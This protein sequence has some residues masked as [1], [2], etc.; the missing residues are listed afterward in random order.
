LHSALLTLENAIP[1]LYHFCALLSSDPYV[2]TRPQFGFEEDGGNIAA[3]VTLPLA[4]DPT[5]RVACSLK[6]WRTER[7]AAKD[8]AFEAYKMLHANGLVNDNLLPDKEDDDALAA[9]FQKSDKTASMIEVSPALDSWHHVAACQA[10]NP[11]VYHCTQ[12][13]ILGIQE[14]PFYIAFYLPVQLPALPDLTLFWN[15]SKRITVK[16]HRLQEATLSDE[17]LT[18][19][20]RLTRKILNSVHSARIDQ[21]RDDFPWLL[22]PSDVTQPCWDHAALVEWDIATSSVIPASHLISRGITDLNRWGQIKV[23]ED[24][25]KWLARSIRSHP[26]S[27]SEQNATLR[28]VRVAKRRDFLY[29]VPKGQRENEAYT[30]T[31]EFAASDCSVEML[32]SAYSICAMLV[33]AVLYRY[34]TYLTIDALRLGLLA[35]LS[36]HEVDHMPLL[37][38]ALTSSSTGDISHYQRCVCSSGQQCAFVLLFYRL[39]SRRLPLLF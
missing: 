14:Q 19:M 17:E 27:S 33:P 9:E 26:D 28:V 20:R 34:E 35:P 3:K 11:H 39:P 25:R 18:T 23:Q 12:L 7:M 5:L 13:E 37:V 36:F 15:E 6:T 16:S 24:E 21:S 2:D 38:Q 29:P 22:L 8:V 10:H 32:P 30:R 1:H 4:V 31:E